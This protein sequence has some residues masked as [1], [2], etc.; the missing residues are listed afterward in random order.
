MKPHNKDCS[1]KGIKVF[2]ACENVSVGFIIASEKFAKNTSTINLLVV[3]LA[4]S[5]NHKID[6][7]HKNEVQQIRRSDEYRQYTLA[8]NI[9]EYHIISKFHIRD[10]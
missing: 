9:T 10:I 7:I 5:H 4:V 3:K 6:N 1:I 8:T 2:I